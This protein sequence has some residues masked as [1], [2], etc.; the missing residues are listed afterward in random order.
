VEHLFYLSLPHSPFTR[1]CSEIFFNWY[2][3]GD[4]IQLGP[5]G[6]AATNRPIVPPP[7][8]YDDGE[9]GGMMIGKGNRNTLRKPAPVPL[10]PPQTPHDARTRTLAA[11]VGSQGLTAWATAR[12]CSEL[13]SVLRSHHYG[14]SYHNIYLPITVETVL[15]NLMHESQF[16]I[17]LHGLNV[18]VVPITVGEMALSNLLD[19]HSIAHAHTTASS[20]SQCVF[21]L[22]RTLTLRR[23]T[24]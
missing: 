11:A 9:I 21:A 15:Q 18:D 20:M 1:L 2:S 3:G 19:Y 17:R 5:L 24:K 16:N 10:C 22:K 7:G 23:M 4:G 12:P 6:T 8:D 14:M 13:V